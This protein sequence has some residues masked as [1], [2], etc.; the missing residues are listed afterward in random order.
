M[1]SFLDTDRFLFSHQ[2]MLLDGSDRMKVKELKMGVM[3]DA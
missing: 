2:F 3:L 1:G